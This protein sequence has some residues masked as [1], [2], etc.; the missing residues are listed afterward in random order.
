L[1]QI[2]DPDKTICGWQMRLHVVLQRIERS[3]F[4]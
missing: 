3:A 4:D 1:T 2:A